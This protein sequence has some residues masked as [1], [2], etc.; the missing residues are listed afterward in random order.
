MRVAVAIPEERYKLT[1][2]VLMVTTLQ[3]NICL[4]TIAKAV[5]SATCT[6]ATVRE[7]DTGH[8]AMLEKPDELNTVIDEYLG[9]LLAV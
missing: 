1:H 7:L 3:D 5:T 6:N 9:N 2:P 4:S 8:W